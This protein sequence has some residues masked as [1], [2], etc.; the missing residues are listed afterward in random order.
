MAEIG[1]ER[2]KPRAAAPV[3]GA[4]APDVRAA[5]DRA[6]AGIARVRATPTSDVYNRL[7]PDLARDV[8]DRLIAARGDGTLAADPDYYRRKLGPWCDAAAV[9]SRA[10]APDGSAP[11]VI[12]ALTRDFS[13]LCKGIAQL[14]GNR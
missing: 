13:A 14:I 10:C 4:D 1:F 8:R 12:L 11:R 5:L 6:A 9:G 7:V 3:A 2:R